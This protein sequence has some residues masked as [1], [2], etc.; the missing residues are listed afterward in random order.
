MQQRLLLALS[1]ALLVNATDLHAQDDYYNDGYW[2]GIPGM[3]DDGIALRNQRT[4]LFLLGTATASY[5]ASEFFQDETNLNYY[6]ARA[7]VY[8]ASD[9]TTIA[10]QTFGIEKRVCRCYRAPFAGCL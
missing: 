5:I 1:F 6:Q 8:G 2:P 9:S 7:G 3:N 10:L 4:F